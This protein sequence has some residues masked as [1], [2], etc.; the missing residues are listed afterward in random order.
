MK[1]P[2]SEAIDR[3]ARFSYYLTQPQFHHTNGERRPITNKNIYKAGII[4]TNRIYPD[5]WIE[6]TYG[7]NTRVVLLHECELSEK[8]LRKFEANNLKLLKQN[9]FKLWMN[10]KEHFVVP[11]ER[12]FEFE[13]IIKESL[14]SLPLKHSIADSPRSLPVAVAPAPAAVVPAAVAPVAVVP[15]PLVPHPSQKLRAFALYFIILF[16]GFHLRTLVTL[17][18]YYKTP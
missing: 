13:M 12:A 18:E 11:P 5:I 6:E 10:K 4:L 3:M 2:P 15:T 7:K 9:G 8:A 16:L 1:S 14:K 17:M